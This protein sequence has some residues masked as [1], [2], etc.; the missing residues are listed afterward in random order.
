[1]IFGEDVLT[2]QLQQNSEDLESLGKAIE[3][4]S[5]SIEGCINAITGSGGLSS[6]IQELGKISS[7]S[8]A[9]IDKLVKS[10]KSFSGI[11]SGN[12][13]TESNKSQDRA[14]DNKIKKDK[15]KEGGNSNVTAPSP[16]N[17]M[18]GLGVGGI[19]TSGVGLAARTFSD[20]VTNSP[21]NAASLANRRQ[22]LG[23][24]GGAFG[25]A[26]AGAI[27]GFALGSVVPV[28]GNA[29]GAAIGATIGGIAGGAGGSF[30]GRN[31][32]QGQLT[33]TLYGQ[34]FEARNVSN[35]D[36]ASMRYSNAMA[37]ANPT[38][39]KTVIQDLQNSRQ[40]NL[41]GDAGLSSVQEQSSLLNIASQSRYSALDPNQM[42]N[43]M[44][45]MGMQNYE[46]AVNTLNRSSAFR[47]NPEQTITNYRDQARQ[48]PIAAQGYASYENQG[49]VGKQT[50]N[51]M[52]EAFFGGNFEEAQKMSPEERLK[53]LERS[54]GLQG[55]Q[56]LDLSK[57]IF[58]G[59][60]ALSSL[61]DTASPNARGNDIDNSELVE[62][63]SDVVEALN[64]NKEAIE[65]STKEANVR[66]R[67]KNIQPWRI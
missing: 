60:E 34:S 14:I 58:S 24:G 48:S 64:A 38:V 6:V 57:D 22:S 39:S 32:S 42:A 27:A 3:T 19:L 30:I 31:V 21:D 10:I 44:Q 63:L 2:V 37:T 54:T 59:N 55:Q 26:G 13:Y 53:A 61:G 25:G 9:D 1:M 52:S 65:K 11:G 43:L 15:D 29:V 33:N 18:K 4:L 45:D 17:L 67:R 35:E 16:T 7:S 41:L 40:N 20:F 23:A 46:G 50:T 62:S 49:F 5:D 8:A 66:Q 28:I 51:A 36:L 56:A 47:I 12:I